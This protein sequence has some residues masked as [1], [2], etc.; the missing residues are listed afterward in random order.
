[1][2]QDILKRMVLFC[3]AAAEVHELNDLV[4]TLFMGCL[5]DSYL[6]KNLFIRMHMLFFYEVNQMYVSW[7][8]DKYQ[9]ALHGVKKKMLK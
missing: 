3:K 2:E 9:S 7:Q 1:M 6:P 5:V 4:T 8:L